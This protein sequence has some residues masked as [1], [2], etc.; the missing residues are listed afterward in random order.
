MREN[1]EI[2]AFP[3]SF[4]RNECG[5]ARCGKNVIEE[6]I[7]RLNRFHGLNCI[8]MDGNRVINCDPNGL[9]VEKIY[10]HYRI[11]LMPLKRE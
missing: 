10:K 4:V 6:I 3:V 1:R 5:Y 8:F 9:P 11:I 2:K 7:F